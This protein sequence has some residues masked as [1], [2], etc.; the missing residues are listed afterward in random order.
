MG[1]H[2]GGKRS[3]MYICVKCQNQMWC[4][5]NEVGADFG[6]GHVFSSDRFECPVCKHRILVVGRE[7]QPMRDP[8]YD[9]Q[10]EYLKVLGQ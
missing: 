1:V 6:N 10:T 7:T 5:K 4:Q 2:T 8:D 9:M 3:E